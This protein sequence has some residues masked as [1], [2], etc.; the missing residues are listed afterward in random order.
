MTTIET[1]ETV[2]FEAPRTLVR[3]GAVFAGLAFLLGLS[4]LL[5][6]FGSALGVTISDATDEAGRGLGIGAIVWLLVTVLVAYFCGGLLAGRLAGSTDHS[7]GMLHGLTLWGAAT[8]AMLLLGYWGLSSMIAA[9]QSLAVGAWRAGSSVASATA[10]GA[11]GAASAGESSPFFAEIQAA[12]KTRVGAALADASPELTDAEARQA[13]EEIDAATLAAA[14]RAWITTG[15]EGAK[16]A[17]ARETTLS[18]QE[19]DAIVADV[20]AAG[21]EQLAA[22]RSE[23]SQT[24]E[25]ISDYTAGTL[26]G[27]FALTVLALLACIGGGW[28]GAEFVRRSFAAQLRVGR[29]MG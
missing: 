24:I 25:T 6:L 7:S 9:G 10:Q 16:Q 23:A 20:G 22:L 5:F 12:L 13:V 1:R 19:L 21:S 28:V 3:W 11:E 27:F 26:W 17:L 4:W 15:P 8:A 2:L 14:V 18:E 29:A